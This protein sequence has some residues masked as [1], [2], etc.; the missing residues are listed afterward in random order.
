[1]T[2]TTSTFDDTAAAL[3]NL[4]AQTLEDGNN[5]SVPLTAHG[6]STTW[7]AA[8]FDCPCCGKKTTIMAPAHDTLAGPLFEIQ[9]KDGKIVVTTYSLDRGCSVEEFETS[10]DAM[11]A[12]QLAVKRRD[13]ALTRPR[14]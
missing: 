9:G 14:A 7:T 5:D 4:A 13:D 2:N 3:R 10:R 12:M 1:V 8:S 6:R 11:N